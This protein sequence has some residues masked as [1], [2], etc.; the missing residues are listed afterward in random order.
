MTRR[1]PVERPLRERPGE[2]SINQQA[3]RKYVRAERHLPE[4]LLG[5]DVTDRTLPGAH[6]GPGSQSNPGNAEIRQTNM[7][8]GKQD[9]VVWLDV[10]VNDPSFVSIRQRVEQLLGV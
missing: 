2:H 8:V 7:A 9:Y 6:D 10:A 3:H 5:C 4:R 1:R